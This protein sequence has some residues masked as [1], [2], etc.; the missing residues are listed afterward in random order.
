MYTHFS[1]TFY[2]FSQI[3]NIKRGSN[4]DWFD[5]H[6]SV[7][8]KLF[9]DPLLMLHDG[10]RWA[11]A[12][13]E[14]IDYFGRCYELVAKSSNEKDTNARAALRMLH[15]PEPE[16]F[17]LGYT[18]HGTK[19]S[20]SGRGYAKK[21]RDGI[22]VAIAAGL[23]K[24]E[25]IEEIGILCEGIGA[26]RIS[27][28]VANVL[29][30]RFVEYTQEVAH[31]HSIQMQLFNIDHY[32][33]DFDYYRA[34]N[35]RVNLPATPNGEPIILVPERILS[36][37][38]IL[39]ANDWFDSDLNQDL[40]DSLNRKVGQSVPKS[41]IVELARRH[42]ERIRQWANAQTSRPDLQGYDFSSDPRG[43]VK[44]DQKAREFAEISPIKVREINSSE[45][46]IELLTEVIHQFKRY[47]E[48]RRGWK[49][50]WNDDGRE[51][52]EEAVQLAFLGMAAEYL[53]LFDVELDREVELGR[54][55]V[56]FKLSRGTRVRVL[57]EVKKLENGKLW[58][59]LER[60]FLSYLSSDESKFGWVIV[61]QYNNETASQARRDELPDRIRTLSE[62]NGITLKYSIIDAIPKE[63]A[64]KISN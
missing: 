64:S 51:K 14:L 18:T 10:G 26:D 60:Q 41:E 35:K 32:E 39:N 44:W 55:P 3:F 9:I 2:R 25:H 23:D 17:H 34:V 21:I 15:F 54:G 29:K 57:I 24:P 30:P 50:L 31:R 58:H 11:Q 33:M 63:S 27:D 6:L 12:H 4:E 37:L 48:Q 56:D 1:Q 46:L 36:T 49:M 40:R 28:I 59:G 61:V 45:D 38:P 16:E 52:N 5:P 20:G 53:R 43:I 19:G 13:N 22:T 62:K 8:T 47:I 7:D 42:P